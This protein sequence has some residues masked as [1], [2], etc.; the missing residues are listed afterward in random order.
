MPPL[1]VTLDVASRH[2]SAPRSG[3]T[4]NVD[5]EAGNVLG[6]VTPRDAAVLRD[7]GAVRSSTQLART[8]LIQTSSDWN[9]YVHWLDAQSLPGYRRTGAGGAQLT[10]SRLLPGD[11]LEIEIAE[12]L[13][14][15]RSV[16]ITFLLPLRTEE[17]IRC[18][19]PCSARANRIPTSHDPR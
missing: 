2:L 9:Q 11:R 17:H 10:Y 16:T 4:T 18:E 1:A 19:H 8:R 12:V 14:D 13:A 7:R 5:R 3:V 15:H 6:L